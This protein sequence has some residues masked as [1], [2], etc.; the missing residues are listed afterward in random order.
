MGY[1]M[2]GQKMAR[3]GFVNFATSLFLPATNTDEYFYPGFI[4]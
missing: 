4:A 3:S 2:E 1:E